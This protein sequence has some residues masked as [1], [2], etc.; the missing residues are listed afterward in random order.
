VQTL[1]WGKEF[2]AQP[3]TLVGITGTVQVLLPL[4]G[5]VDVATLRSKIE[6]D[7]Q[8]IQAQATGLAARLNNTNFLAKA[9]P[10]VVQTNQA[11]LAE[12]TQQMELLQS[13]LQQLQ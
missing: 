10:E 8:K 13:R 3:Q 4:A 6:R 9:P 2:T 5:L 12:L 7:V 1:T 11:Q